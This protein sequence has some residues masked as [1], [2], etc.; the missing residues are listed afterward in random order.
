M[1]RFSIIQAIYLC[2][3]PVLEST[4][5]KSPMFGFRLTASSTRA[6]HG[7]HSCNP[8]HYNMERP[9][10]IRHVRLLHR[11]SMTINHLRPASRGCREYDVK[12]VKERRVLK[13]TT[14]MLQALQQLL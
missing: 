2:T 1:L 5:P 13:A 11:A 6:N 7:G 10:Y 3:Q 14:G 12:L 4:M 8:T 9:S